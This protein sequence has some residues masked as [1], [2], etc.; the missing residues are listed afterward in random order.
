MAD[1]KERL[2]AA[3]K[4]VIAVRANPRNGILLFGEP[5]NGK[6]MFAEA[7][8]GELNVPFFSIA[9]SDIASMWVNESVQ[10]VKAA[11]AA[12]RKTGFGVFFID[13]ID[14]FLKERGGGGSHHM[15]R[16]LTNSM[17]TEIVNLRG[18]KIVLVAATNHLDDLDSAGVARSASTSRWKSRHRTKRLAKQFCAVRSA[19]PPVTTLPNRLWSQHWASVGQATARRV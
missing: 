3:A 13:E 5:G 9:Y 18:T 10:K 15:D 4:D 8:A 14:S 7:L 6:T 17:L 19:A 16:D 12:A 11:F 1:T 2:L